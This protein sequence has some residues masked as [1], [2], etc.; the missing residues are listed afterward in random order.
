MKQKLSRKTLTLG[1]ITYVA[2]W[3]CEKEGAGVARVPVEMMRNHK[4]EIMYALAYGH[5]FATEK[6]LRKRHGLL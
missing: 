2:A 5:G 3:R 6:E 1:N 4:G